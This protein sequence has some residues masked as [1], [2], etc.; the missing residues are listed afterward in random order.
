[1]GITRRRLVAG[2][3]S[4]VTVV[5]ALVTIDQWWSQRP[6]PEAEAAKHVAA[7]AELVARDHPDATSPA[8]Q[9]HLSLMHR[10]NLDMRGVVVPD[11][12]LVMAAF[13]GVDWSDVI[14]AGLRLVCSDGALEAIDSWE[15]GARKLPFCARLKSAVFSAAGL[16]RALVEYADLA[17]ANFTGADLTR[18]R[19]RMS[20]VTNA[21][22]LGD[23]KLRGIQIQDSDFSNTQ[24]R[25]NAKFT[26][27]VNDEKWRPSGSL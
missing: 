27:S 23:V 2:I 24:F 18:A 25:R 4:L 20:V 21:N 8:I 10:D 5:A 15:R 11:L 19:I 6:D 13:D 12:T 16:S 3:V 17:D 7:I 22:F 26:C 9:K 1:M 14:M